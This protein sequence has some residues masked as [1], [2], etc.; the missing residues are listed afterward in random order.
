MLDS[1]RNCSAI[2]VTSFIQNGGTL[3]MNCKGQANKGVSIDGNGVINNGII[4]I[5]TTGNAGYYNTGRG[6]DTYACSALTG[7]GDL[8]LIRGTLTFDSIGS[9]GKGIHCAQVLTMGKDACAG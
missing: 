2:K 3:T 7:D 5:K 9:G 8:S 4:D 6:Y 1:L